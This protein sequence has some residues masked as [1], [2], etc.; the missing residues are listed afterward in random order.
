M[1][2][3]HNIQAMNANRIL[4]MNNTKLAGTLEKL[5]SGYQVNRSA[6]NAAGLA[7]SEKMRTMIH[8][9]TQ[10][11]KNCHDAVSLVQTAE[12]AL[13]EVHSML[14]RMNELANQAANGSYSDG[15]D[16]ASLQLE[17]TQIQEEIDHVAEHT[18]FNGM[19]LFDGTGGTYTL[20]SGNTATNY[21]K[22]EIPTLEELLSDK[23]GNLQNII[24]TETVFDFETT[25][26][27]Q[28]AN[29]TS[30][31]SQTYKDTA[32][33]LQTSIV[34]QAVQAILNKY[35]AFNYLT[36]SSIGIGLELYSDSSTT[37]ASVSVAPEAYQNTQTG[38]IYA[39]GMTYKLRV[40]M[41]SVDL[42]TEEGRNALESTIAHEMIHAFM[43]EALTAGML[44]ITSE[45][46]DSSQQFPMWFIEGMAQTASGPGNWVY[47]GL[48]ITPDSTTSEIKSALAG[49]PLTSSGSNTAAQYGTGYLACMYL[50]YLAAGSD[51]NI[52]SSTAAASD[53][54]SGLNSI[55][56]DVI[57]GK[58]LNSVINEISGGKYST[59]SAFASGFAN[60]TAVQNFIQEMAQQG[61]FST[62]Y[63]PNDSWV[64]DVVS[65]GLISGD[66]L[67]ADPYPN[68]N[69]SL[70]LFALDKNN[71]AIKNTYPDGVTVL[72]GGTVSTEGV[73]PMENMPETPSNQFGD[74]TVTG[75]TEGIDFEYDEVTGTLTVLT[76]TALKIEG[77]GNA[78]TDKIKIADGI[79]ANVT[80]K[81]VNID[82]SST[83]G[84]CAFE[85]GD[86]ATLNL[87]LDGANALI[88]G[89]DC[90]G[91]QVGEGETLIITENSTGYLNAIGGYFAAGIGGGYDGSGG[92]ID[93]NAGF[94]TAIGGIG[95]A[96][97]GGGTRGSGGNVEISGGDVTATGSSGA[98]AIGDGRNGS[99]GTFSTGTNGNADIT[100][101]NADGDTE[102]A[103][104]ISDTSGIDVW[105]AKINGVQYPI[106]PST[107]S[108]TVTGGTY[109]TDYTYDE[110]T[111]TLT[112]LTGTALKIE[113][114]GSATTDKIKIGDG[115]T[116]NVTIKNVNIDVR[117]GAAIEVGDGA[118]LNLTLEGSNTLKGGN[119]CAGLQVGEGETL[120]ITENSTGSLNSTGGDFGA[121][122][123]GAHGGDG[124]TIEINGGT[125]T[126]IGGANGAGIGG[127]F[128]GAGGTIDISGGIVTATGGGEAAG[129][130]GGGNG[131]GGDVE[132]SGGE[133]T[134]AGGELGAGIGGGACGTGGTIDISGGT[135]TATGGDCGAG[136]GGGVAGAGGNVEISGG[137]VTA[138][139]GSN[140][141]AIGYGTEGSGDVTFSTG[142]NGNAD[143]TVSNADGD[144]E[145]ADLISDTSGIDVWSAKINGVQYPKP[146]EGTGNIDL[147]TLTGDLEIVD[148]GYKIGDKTYTYS[149]D[150]TF[151]GTTDKNI[152]VSNGGT[153]NISLDGAT[154]GEFAVKGNSTVN[155]NVTGENTAEYV[156]VENGSKLNITGD[157]TLNTNQGIGNEGTLTNDSTINNDGA[158]DNEG[159]L[160]NGEN[161]TINNGFAITNKGSIT[162][163][164][165]INNESGS[166]INNNTGGTITNN[167]DI[168]NESGGTITNTGG[169]LTNNGNIDN[170]GTVNNGTTRASGTIKNNG[171]ID[172][173]GDISNA[174][175][176]NIENSG[177]IN[178]ENSGSIS[179]SGAVTNK[180]GGE[181]SNS[182]D[183]TNNDSGTIANS[184]NITN[185][186]SGSIS[187]SGE[188]TN[189]SGG[190][191]ENAGSVTNNDGGTIDN[192]GTITNSGEITNAS[193]GTIDN[194]GDIDSTSGTLTNNGEIKS[195]P[196][197]NIDGTV[198]GTQPTD[199]PAKAD[200]EDDEDGDFED[201]ENVWIMQT[202]GRSKDTFVM[203]IGRMNTKILGVHKDDINIS[204]QMNANRAI[205]VIGEAVNK[206][207]TQRADIGAYQKRLEHKIDNLN[208]TRENLIAAE[209]KIRDTNM[210]AYMMQFTKN[211]ILNNTAQAML[212][213]ATSLP[214]GIMSLVQ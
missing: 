9:I 105:S 45:A 38:E 176:G 52:S 138:T 85:V 189:K 58:S 167:G 53:I 159:T 1:I 143:I 128:G 92:T 126:A 23:L 59:A 89:N 28:S 82:V 50:G 197:S 209:S 212:A 100:V 74:F 99:G 177:D 127:G 109:G 185:E 24:Y 211:Q 125:V 121:G 35:S 160:T 164:G 2:V 104:L 162:N 152:T 98:A 120:V 155:M 51:A 175:R 93:I 37:L 115:I 214:Q 47:H 166:T 157:G 116:A 124:G 90:A 62:D 181:I 88:S 77:T 132:I 41:N 201:G 134:A 187:N 107:G 136:I 171:T 31:W 149:G 172:N 78:T 5:S 147:S 70:N 36:G 131:A 133:V 84:A 91:L 64:S 14:Q 81:N 101:R 30:S 25:Q 40:N 146:L 123:G 73:K 153:T 97:I 76:G 3:Q 103:D 186:N 65:G 198:S 16:R 32:N 118:T 158:L 142:T 60:D 190:T 94:V 110:S 87:T 112:V 130:G 165:D 11:E 27:G 33:A 49:D 206:L 48:G 44:G 10:A 205:D 13:N 54:L 21:V 210:A 68:S 114:T 150:Y 6:D 173:S 29:N 111:G 57:S 213:Q 192:S 178:N 191:V 108:F 61:Y 106:P 15:V 148:G 170:D 7:I 4:G 46:V 156:H 179:N 188:V 80:I 67:N 117:G 119:S 72:S 196:D 151:T 140:A 20:S 39:T 204:T 66:L 145:I 141:D 135:V 55:L 207:S 169:T 102:I 194:N 83:S 43:D 174:A 113:G 71:T 86:G 195:R 154:L 137:D 208:V 8:G 69:L 182:G 63:T 79:T 96:G 200:G 180:S 161:G 34:P 56:S 183:V 17:F 168:N 19:K 129:I 199:A 184:G 95:A 42:S 202:G 22:K 12:G 163:N 122:I 18:D 139:G 144:T 75:G 26:S 203:D 193:G